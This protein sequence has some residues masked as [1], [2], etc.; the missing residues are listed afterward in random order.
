MEELADYANANGLTLTGIWHTHRG[1][2]LPS[3]LG[4]AESDIQ[5]VYTGVY[6]R[7]F[8]RVSKNAGYTIIG[9][10]PEGKGGL[11]KTSIKLEY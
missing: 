1:E 6:L 11:F 7:L 5:E 2:A 4:G 10:H 9:K 3:V 8:D